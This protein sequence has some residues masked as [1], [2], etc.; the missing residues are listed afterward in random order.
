MMMISA[1]AIGHIQRY[2]L[3]SVQGPAW[4]ESPALKRSQIGIMKAR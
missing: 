4:N 2:L 3:P 1:T